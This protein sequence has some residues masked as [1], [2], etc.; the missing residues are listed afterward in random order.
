MSTA[1][2]DRVLS[3]R[4]VSFGKLRDAAVELLLKRVEELTEGEDALMALHHIEHLAAVA[5]CYAELLSGK[6]RREAAY[7]RKT[8]EVDARTGQDWAVLEGAS[9]SVL[10]GAAVADVVRDCYFR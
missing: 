5:R 7:W 1:T 6:K 4:E 2:V 8:G 3:P 10:S 9:T